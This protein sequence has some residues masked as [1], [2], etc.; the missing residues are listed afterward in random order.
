M[1]QPNKT[2]KKIVIPAAAGAVIML[3]VAFLTGLASAENAQMVF[4]RLCDGAFAAGVI[5]AG[6]G[7]LLFA[8]NEGQF[9]IL[10]FGVKQVI[11]SFT[12]KDLSQDRQTFYDYR[13]EKSKHKRPVRYILLVGAGYLLLSGVFLAIYYMV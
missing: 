10:S 12:R 8:S 11:R 7:G 3:G 9:D 13:A 1:E 4:R 5:L 6:F 2:G